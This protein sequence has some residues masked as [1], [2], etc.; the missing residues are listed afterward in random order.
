MANPFYN[1]SGTPATSSAGSSAPIRNEYALIAAGFDKMPA[2]TANTVVIVNSGGTALT[3]TVGS[4]TLGGNLS[5]AGNFTISGAFNTTLVA[6]A[7]ISITLPIVA[8]TLATL[9]NAEVLTNKTISGA[10]NT[11]SAIANASLTNS[12]ITIGGTSTALGGTITTTTMLDSIGATRGQVLYRGAAGWAALATGTANFFL[13]TGGA[14]ADPSWVQGLL[15]A[16]NLSDVA[17]ATTSR[18]NLGI[19]GN[20]I[21]TNYTIQNGGSPG[22]GSSGDLFFIW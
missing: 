10:S 9:A 16:S 6:G 11:L 21:A 19:T 4:L 15:S 3:N 7:S 5:I 1:T 12:S 17:N 14:G 22:G 18:G 13:R 2:L 20:M 8:G